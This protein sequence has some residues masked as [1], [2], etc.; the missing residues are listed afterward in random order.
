MSKLFNNLSLSFGAIGAF[1][2]ALIGGFDGMIKALLVFVVLD[3]FTGVLVAICKEK[4]SSEVGFKGILKK[5]TI[6]VMV[7]VANIIDGYVLGGQNIT[8]ATVILFYIANEGISI[9]ENAGNLGLPLPGG[10]K[11]MLV[12]L[13]KQTEDT[14]ILTEAPEDKET[15]DENNGN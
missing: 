8:R 2:G 9:C 12:Q 7:G 5:V 6:F 11:K 15:E 14:E 1:I 3:Y 10:L 13:K 4:L